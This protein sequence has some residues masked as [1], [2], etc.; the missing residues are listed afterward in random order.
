MLDIFQRDGWAGLMS[1][2][3]H[4]AAYYG[5]IA[6]VFFSCFSALQE[7]VLD[8][9]RVTY[10]LACVHRLPPLLLVHTLTWP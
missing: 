8:E 1:G 3:A 7:L 2:A 4:R 5:P 10:M 6:G 9:G